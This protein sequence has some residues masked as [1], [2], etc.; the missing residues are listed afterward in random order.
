MDKN[1]TGARALIVCI[2]ILFSINNGVAENLEPRLIKAKSETSEPS[3]FLNNHKATPTMLEKYSSEL[4]RQREKIHKKFID[5]LLNPEVAVSTLDTQITA[6]ASVNTLLS[7]IKEKAASLGQADL[8]SEISL[9]QT[10]YYERIVQ[11]QG[12]IE[13]SSELENTLS[14]LR[15]ML[16][17]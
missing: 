8:A 15:E 9:D 2:I 14:S 5:S 1:K 6:L 11:W 12:K 17:K 16:K 13:G 3:S 7:D 10:R 4:K